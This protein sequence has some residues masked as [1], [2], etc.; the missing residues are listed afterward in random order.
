MLAFKGLTLAR[1]LVMVL[2]ACTEEKRGE[3]S[4]A[5]SEGLPSCPASTSR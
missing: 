4:D 2:A 1:A 5:V 3:I